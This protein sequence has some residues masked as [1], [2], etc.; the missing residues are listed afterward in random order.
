MKLRPVG[1]LYNDL[2]LAKYTKHAPKGFRNPHEAIES[3]DHVHDASELVALL[4][5]LKQAVSNRDFNES[6]L[7]LADISGLK[8]S[9]VGLVNALAE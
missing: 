4:P 9:V 2:S 3:I 5:D 8:P 1:R 6:A 7:D